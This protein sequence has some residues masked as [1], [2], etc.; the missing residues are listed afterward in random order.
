M[1]TTNL[2]TSQSFISPSTSKPYFLSPPSNNSISIHCR[3]LDFSASSSSSSSSS[4]P[5]WF[6]FPDVSGPRY[7]DAVL[8]GSS[9]SSSNGSNS[10]KLE[11][12]WSRN[13][14]S[15]LTDDSDPLPLPMTYPDSTPVSPDEIE[16]RLRCDPQIED[17]KVVVYEW[18]GKCR[19]CQGTG[20]VDY[21][22][23]RGRITCKCIP[24]LGIGYV[25]KITARDDI[26]LMED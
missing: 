8:G 7:N 24:C 25:R 10:G 2:T 14:E 12:K 15:Y 13:R 3:A 16:R 1:F 22:N 21:Y 11:K 17:C 18:T 23:K 4:S 9:K 6:Q 26:E 20:Y 5:N 19:S